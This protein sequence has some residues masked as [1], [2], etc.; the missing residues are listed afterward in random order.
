[1]K[2][3]IEIF[4]TVFYSGKSP[5]APGT[6]GTLM[7]IPIAW[8]LSKYLNPLSVMIVVFLL[9]I[10]GVL[11]CEM[12]LKEKGGEDRQEIVIDEVVGYLIATLWL[13]WTWQTIFATFILFRLLDILK[14][15]P[16]GAVDRKVKGGLGVM[17]DDVFAGLIV[18]VVLQVVYTN[19]NLLG[20]Q[21]APQL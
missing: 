4:V 9:L 15:G 19:T 12:Y 18:N 5:K 21:L 1:L 6:V 2:N 3:I 14:P 7:A 16:I 13:P 10:L 20:I 11:A 8:L 17:L